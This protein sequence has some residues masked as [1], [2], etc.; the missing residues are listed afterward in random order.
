MLRQHNVQRRRDLQIADVLLRG[1]S[2]G[3]VAC[4]GGKES[5]ASARY[6]FG[7]SALWVFWVIHAIMLAVIIWWVVGCAQAAES[8]SQTFYD[9][10]SIAS[11]NLFR[12]PAGQLRQAGS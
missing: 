3:K 2:R 5:W 9:A 4:N 6:A 12:A 11:P 10:R 8:R 7:Y 1:L